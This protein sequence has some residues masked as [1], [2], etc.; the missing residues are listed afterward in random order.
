MPSP[1]L[2]LQPPVDGEPTKR[3]PY[4]AETIKAA[5]IKCRF[6]HSDLDLDPQTG[7]EVAEDDEIWEEEEESEPLTLDPGGRAYARRDRDTTPLPRWLL[8]PVAVAVLATLVL[9]GLAVKD[10]READD[11]AAAA[12][13]SQSVRAAV[14]DKVEALLSYQYDTFDQDRATAEKSMTSSFR[15]EYA[16]TVSEIRDR[17]TQQKRSQE[18]QVAAVSVIS[19]TPDTVKT[20]VFV[21]T[22]SSTEGSKRQRLMQNRVEVTMVKQGDQWLIDELAV[23]T[24]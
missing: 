7:R 16:P 18:A 12:D 23:P 6:C 21:N 19:A 17:A 14:T 11:L 3:C 4:C 15:A 9:L 5:A 10:W 20:L 24:S 2:D 8:V 22:M 1:D 13:A